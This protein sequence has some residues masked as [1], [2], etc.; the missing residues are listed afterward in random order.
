MTSLREEALFPGEGAPY[1]DE[2]WARVAM[3]RVLCD[4]QLLEVAPILELTLQKGGWAAIHQVAKDMAS[5]AKVELKLWE[6][7]ADQTDFR[8]AKA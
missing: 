7:L 1:T 6:D 4:S 8:E 3:D 5:V 2:E